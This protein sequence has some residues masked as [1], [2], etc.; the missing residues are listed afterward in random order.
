V[1]FAGGILIMGGRA[2]DNKGW[3]P[4]RMMFYDPVRKTQTGVSSSMFVCSVV[5]FTLSSENDFRQGRPI[6]EKCGH[7]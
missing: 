1:P 3:H 7:A 2:N 4:N 5:H 6:I